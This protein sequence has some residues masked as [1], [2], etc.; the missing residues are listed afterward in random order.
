[1]K[2]LLLISALLIFGFTSELYSQDEEFNNS[3]NIKIYNKIISTGTSKFTISVTKGNKI[4]LPISF[5]KLEE[6]G[7]NKIEEFC[8]LNLYNFKIINIDKQ[9]KA[10]GKNDRI[11]NLTGVG[12]WTGNN[13]WIAAGAISSFINSQKQ[14]IVTLTFNVSTKDGSF[15]MSKEQAR[16]ELIKLKEL[17]D[18]DIITKSEFD[19]R[20]KP[21]KEIV[22]K[23][24]N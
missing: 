12:L 1:M 20:A 16:I 11:Y 4:T 3:T 15:T 5:K 2:K 18:M 8:R 6:I 19:K 22:L 9:K 21:L 10:L 14:K 7:Y 23:T 24:G 17:Y 13:E